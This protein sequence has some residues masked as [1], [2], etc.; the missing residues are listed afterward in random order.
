MARHYSALSIFSI[1]AHPWTSRW[2]DADAQ[3]RAS[4]RF[5]ICEVFMV[6]ASLG[7]FSRSSHY[8]T[9]TG[10]PTIRI[11]LSNSGTRSGRS[12]FR[13]TIRILANPNI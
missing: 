10:R 5:S 4:A 11:L 13:D 9:G 8:R 12:S 1:I 2:V 6:L 3:S 7:R